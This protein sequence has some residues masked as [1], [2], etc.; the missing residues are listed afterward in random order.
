MKTLSLFLSTLVLAAGLRSVEISVWNQPPDARPAERQIWDEEAKAFSEASGVQVHPIAR[1]YIQQQFVSV[2]AGGKG[3]DVAHVWVG[4]LPSLAREGLLAPLDK[5]AGSW[6][7]KDFVPDV[8]WEPARL[9]GHLYGVP[10][11]SYVYVLLVRKDLWVKAGLDPAV[12]PATWADLEAAARKLTRPQDNVA[13]FG[14]APTAEVFME[15]LWQA[16]GDLFRDQE[17]RRSACFQENAGVEAVS[18][19]RHLRFEAQVTQS[20]PLASQDE[21]AQLFALGKVAM[22]LGVPDQMPDLIS[23]YG[24]KPQDLLLFPLPAGPTGIHATQVGGDYYVVNA[25]SDAPH[26]AAAWAYIEAMLAPLNQLRRWHRMQDLGLPVFPGAFSTTAQLNGL[27]EFKLVQDTLVTAR[28]EPNLP[29]WP[30]IK[31]HLETTL[32]QRLFTQ[33]D[34]DVEGLLRQSAQDVDDLYL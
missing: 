14:F 17:G 25:Q 13:G 21:L 11:D 5:E 4:A 31:D 15:F 7:Q 19:L 30:Q 33:E 6:E 26:R 1:H 24:L 20:N 9:D 3:P 18:F 27:P 2:M 28:P 23:R 22:L 34:A 12:P 29:N 8:L 32:L 16:G 10:R